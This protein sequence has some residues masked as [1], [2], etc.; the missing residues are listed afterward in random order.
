MTTDNRFFF[1]LL[2]LYLGAVLIGLSVHFPCG[3]EH[4]GEI[5]PGFLIPGVVLAGGYW[6]ALWKGRRR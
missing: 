2:G 5:V 4:S 6:H 3:S 1:Q